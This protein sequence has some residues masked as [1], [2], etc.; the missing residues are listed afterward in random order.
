MAAGFTG[1]NL[2]I[3]DVARLFPM[4][5]T[6]RVSSEGVECEA[7][8]RREL[9]RVLEIDDNGVLPRGKAYLT[10]GTESGAWRIHG[11]LHRDRRSGWAFF[12]VH[13][14]ARFN[15]RSESRLPVGSRQLFVREAGVGDWYEVSAV[16]LSRSGM[17]IDGAPWAPWT[18]LEVVGIDSEA[19]PTFGRVVRND[20]GHCALRFERLTSTARI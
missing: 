18:R 2:S 5:T 20:D 6:V 12:T 16:D 15:R 1:L 4:P 11:A 7:L 14:G 13:Q 19:E 9:G 8:A 3:D 10:L 17:A